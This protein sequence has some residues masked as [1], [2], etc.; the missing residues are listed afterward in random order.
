MPGSVVIAAFAII[1]ASVTF[2]V[3]VLVS[4]ASKVLKRRVVHDRSA[5]E[6]PQRA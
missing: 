6:S 5:L 1:V 3:G 2:A 4:D